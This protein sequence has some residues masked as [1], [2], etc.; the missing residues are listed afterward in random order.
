MWAFRLQQQPAAKQKLEIEQS[1]DRSTNHITAPAANWKY[2]NG[3]DNIFIMNYNI[4]SHGFAKKLQVKIKP[5]FRTPTKSPHILKNKKP[6]FYCFFAV[7]AMQIEA[8]QN[9]SRSST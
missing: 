5:A 3:L 8:P 4:V 2:L 7:Y 1:E 6:D 9:Y